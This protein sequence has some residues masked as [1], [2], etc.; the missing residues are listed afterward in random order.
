MA[1]KYDPDEFIKSEEKEQPSRRQAAPDERDFAVG[2]AKL[3]AM[4]DRSGEARDFLNK[5]GSEVDNIVKNLKAG[6]DPSQSIG[7]SAN[8][9]NYV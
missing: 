9:S 2:Q 7:S 1:L 4:K 5:Y 3:D 8:R 6:R